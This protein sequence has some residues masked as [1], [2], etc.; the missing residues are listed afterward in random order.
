MDDPDHGPLIKKTKVYNDSPNIPN[1]ALESDPPTSSNPVKDTPP[2]PIDGEN[3]TIENII[4]TSK[5]EVEPPLVLTPLISIRYF[6]Y[7]L[8]WIVDLD[9]DSFR[10]VSK[11][12]PK[13][14]EYY[15]NLKGREVK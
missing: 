2:V 5:S 13:L 14:M 6:E 9:Y 4:I 15:T 1:R 3:P 10:F 8:S 7:C 12:R 11:N